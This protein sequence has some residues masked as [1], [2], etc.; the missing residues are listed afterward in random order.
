MCICCDVG[1]K[2]YLYAD[3]FVNAAEKKKTALVN[4]MVV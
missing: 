2:V 4:E 1:E 3:M